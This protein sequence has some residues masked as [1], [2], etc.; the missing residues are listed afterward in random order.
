MLYNNKNYLIVTNCYTLYSPTQ[1]RITPVSKAGVWTKLFQVVV[2]VL[3]SLERK[4]EKPVFSASEPFFLAEASGGHTLKCLVNQHGVNWVIRRTLRHTL[5]GRSAKVFV[6]DEV[7]NT[8]FRG[9]MPTVVITRA[10]PV[11]TP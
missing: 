4:I 8:F 2:S 7:F 5:G 10:A 3:L 9:R 11:H 1:T 6:V